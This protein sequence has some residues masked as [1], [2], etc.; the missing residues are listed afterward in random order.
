MSESKTLSLPV[1]RELTAGELDAVSGGL[2]NNNN[3]GGINT[4]N[5]GNIVGAQIG[6]QFNGLFSVNGIVG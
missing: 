5:V 2:L 1:P 4:V 3:F 6:Q